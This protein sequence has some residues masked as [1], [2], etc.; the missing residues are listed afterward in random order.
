MLCFFALISILGCALQ[1]KLP[2]TSKAGLLAG[3]YRTLPP[4]PHPLILTERGNAV[5]VA[6]A[7]SYAMALSLAV[8]N[9]AGASK[10][11]VVYAIIFCANAIGVS[12]IR[13]TL[14]IHY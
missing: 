12:P 8:S 11:T 3:V 7:G 13:F 9:T 5:I 1:W 14:S 2:L 6:Y 10:K 4:T